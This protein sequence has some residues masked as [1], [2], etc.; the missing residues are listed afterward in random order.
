VTRIDA[1]THLWTLAR[2]DY[3][4]LGPELQPIYRDF[5][6]PDLAPLLAAADMSGTILLQAAPTEAETMFLLPVMNRAGGYAKWLAAT[7]ALLAGWSADERESVFGG[8][9]AR[10]YL[11][12]R[13]PRAG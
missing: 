1:H 12:D 10:V 5:T 8:T 4:W 9:A 11:G 7:E 13:G 2:G 6:L 3:G